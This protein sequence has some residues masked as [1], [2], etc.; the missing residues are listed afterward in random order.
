MTLAYGNVTVTLSDLF[1]VNWKSTIQ[2]EVTLAYGN[3]LEHFQ[4]S[5]TSTGN[6]QISGTE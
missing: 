4:M 3:P 6:L 5:S 2:N 1:D